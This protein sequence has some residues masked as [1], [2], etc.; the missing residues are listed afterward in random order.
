MCV[1]VYLLVLQERA[2][3]GRAAV[4]WREVVEV[5]EVLVQPLPVGAT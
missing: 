5:E 1:A 4:V 2:P 3:V